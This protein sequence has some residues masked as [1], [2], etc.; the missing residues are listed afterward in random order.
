MK[1]GS[2]GGR[3]TWLSFPLPGS[4]TNNLAAFLIIHRLILN[5]I[6]AAGRDKAQR[7]SISDGA[8]AATGPTANRCGRLPV[9]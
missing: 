2:V 4:I 9:Q 1:L 8:A 3:L 7:R 6:V 5:V